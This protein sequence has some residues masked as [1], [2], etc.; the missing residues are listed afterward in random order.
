M[1]FLGNLKS[2]ESKVEKPKDKSYILLEFI[3]N[4]VITRYGKSAGISFLTNKLVEDTIDVIQVLELNNKY[5]I[6]KYIT[7]LVIN[8]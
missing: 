6:K 4:S 8:I 7:I 3:N 2:L 1:A 5:I